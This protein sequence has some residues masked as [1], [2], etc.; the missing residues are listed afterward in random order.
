MK[1]FISYNN[2]LSK[3]MLGSVEDLKGAILF[4][5]MEKNLEDKALI[6]NQLGL[7]LASQGGEYKPFISSSVNEA[8]N[9]NMQSTKQQLDLFKALQGT[10]PTT[11][12]LNQSNTAIKSIGT[13]EA[14]QILEKEGLTKLSYDPD[15]YKTLAATNGLEKVPE[16]RAK[17]MNQ[18]AT[19]GQSL[20]VSPNRNNTPQEPTKHQKRRVIEEDIDEEEFLP[21]T[22]S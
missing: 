2:K 3:M 17:F 13:H 22:E 11:Q 10:G 4:S 19:D 18:S 20:M 7:L 8:L 16:V 9:L 12:I 5:V 21:D 14:M 1:V 15:H 6:Q